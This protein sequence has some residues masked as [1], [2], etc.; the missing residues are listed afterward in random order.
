MKACGCALRRFEAIA[1][2]SDRSQIHPDYVIN[3]LTGLAGTV[4][5]SP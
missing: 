4:Q 2:L 1:A 5:E 3:R